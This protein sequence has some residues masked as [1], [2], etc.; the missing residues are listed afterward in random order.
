MR[1]PLLALLVLPLALAGCSDDDPR[2]QADASAVASSS[3]SSSAPAS[4]APQPSLPGIASSAAVPLPSPDLTRRLTGDGIDLPTGVVV[5]GDALSQAEPAL[6]RFLG[7]PS[8][9]TGRIAATGPYG[10]CPGTD[11]RVLE[12]DGGA[13]QLRFSTRQGGGQQVL[14]SWALTRESSDVPAASALVGDVTTVELRP[15]DS[16]RQ[17]Q[18]GLGGALVLAGDELV[19]PS[20]RVRDQSGGLFGT[21]TT[22]GPDGVVLTVQAGEGCE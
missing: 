19:G 1:S 4:S 16:V 5:F 3:A 2:P 14:T 10:T 11:L 18:Q 6:L 12:Y 9:D 17:L 8:R 15:G 21:L 20:F 7:A 13:L 22:V